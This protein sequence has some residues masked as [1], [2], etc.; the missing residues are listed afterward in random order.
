MNKF[1]QFAVIAICAVI[2]A[3]PGMVR[4]DEDITDSFTDENFLE[5]IYSLIG[6]AA[7][8]TIFASDVS[9]I[10]SLE[11]PDRNIKNLSGIEHF[12]A[13]VVL[14]VSINQLTSINVSA[15]TELSNLNVSNN[16]LRALNLFNNTALRTLNVSDNQLAT[17]NVAVNTALTTLNVSQNYMRLESNVNGFTGTTL[18][19]EPQR[20]A[21]T[22]ITDSLLPPATFGE[23]YSKIIELSSD[24]VAFSW[25]SSVLPLPGLT[26][27]EESGEISGTPTGTGTFT[28]WIFAVNPIEEDSRRFML[29]INPKPLTADMLTD[30]IVTYNGLSQFPVLI[31]GTD[32]L[33]RDTDYTL[34]TTLSLPLLTNAATHSVK[35]IGKGNYTDT[36]SFNF[37]INKKELTADM[38]SIPEVEFNSTAQTP[39]LTVTDPDIGVL[40]RN[41]DY[42]VNLASQTDVGTY[43]ITVTGIGNYAGTPSVN[44]VI[45]SPV[46]VLS[47]ERVI[48]GTNPD[49]QPTS[50]ISPTAISA[51]F[52]AGPNPVAKSAGIVN[53]FYQGKKIQSAA[54]TVF[55]AFGNAVNKISIKD[56]AIGTQ[57][58]R[59]VGSWDL[60]DSKGR[61]VSEGTYL[62]KGTVTVDGKRE[63]VS[64]LIGVK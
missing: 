17:L 45:N 58:R 9:D 4:A 18:T 46:S 54:F 22:I 8:D 2:F 62:V 44:F 30:T 13:L 14:N 27:S 60:T 25:D 51:E 55:D 40:I 21:P 38:L 32:T 34:E 47:P 52:T 61:L 3:V 50:T 49:N 26:M 16:K 33:V 6:K 31:H 28:F 11:I 56:N 23:P 35:V 12:T 24:A 7:P 39:V 20:P 48:P 29:V 15:N 53:F 59:P 43:S 5:A 37:V 41:T 42:Q 1:T 57:E 19:F 63:R 64:L 36:L 10:L